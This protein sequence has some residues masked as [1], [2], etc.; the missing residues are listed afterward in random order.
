MWQRRKVIEFDL[1]WFEFIHFCDIDLDS[2]HEK[3]YV[4]CI[5]WTKLFKK[6]NRSLIT[7]WLHV[8]ETIKLTL[9]Y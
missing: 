3:N 5:K 7:W 9:C 1:I 2:I 6:E 4:I 8:V